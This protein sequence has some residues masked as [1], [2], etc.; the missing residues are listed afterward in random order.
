MS[1]NF[2]LVESCGA[3]TAAFTYSQ[4]ETGWLLCFIYQEITPVA[5]KTIPEYISTIWSSYSILVIHLRR[6]NELG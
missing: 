3:E 6:F 1:K 5:V 4:P 2:K